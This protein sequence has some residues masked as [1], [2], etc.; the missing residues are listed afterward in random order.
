MLDFSV[1]V[2]FRISGAGQ[3]LFGDGIAIWVTDLTE[4]DWRRGGDFFAGPTDF[5]G[6]VVLLD[7]FKNAEVRTC[8]HVYARAPVG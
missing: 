3:R 4:T 6:F 5:K 7:T 8:A 2:N 1:Y